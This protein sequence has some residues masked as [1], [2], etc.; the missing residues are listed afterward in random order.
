MEFRQTF[1]ENKQTLMQLPKKHL[2][3]N[4]WIQQTSV[5]RTQPLN[6]PSVSQTDFPSVV[7]F[8]CHFSPEKKMTTLAE[9][10]LREMTFPFPSPSSNVTYLKKHWCLETLEISREIIIHLHFIRTVALT[11]MPIYG[12]SQCCGAAVWIF[13]VTCW[14][15]QVVKPVSLD[16]CYHLFGWLDGSLMMFVWFIN[17]YYVIMF[18]SLCCWL[19][20][21]IYVCYM[22]GL[23]LPEGDHCRLLVPGFDMANHDPRSHN[24]SPPTT[25]PPL[26]DVSVD[27]LAGTGRTHTILEA[28]NFLKKIFETFGIKPEIMES[29]SM[30]TAGWS[31]CLDRL[32]RLWQRWRGGHWKRRFFLLVGKL[33]EN[34]VEKVCCFF[35]QTPCVFKLRVIAFA[36]FVDESFDV[37]AISDR[38]AS[39]TREPN[40][41]IQASEKAEVFLYRWKTDVASHDATTLVAWWIQGESSLTSLVCSLA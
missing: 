15:M 24:D 5:W 31:C 17:V 13:H 18:S 1:G 39:S 19:D 11:S 7:F 2:L 3:T 4:V 33:K 29:S 32:R 20:V 30:V 6:K 16:G 8:L 25:F 28:Y 35:F 37:R 40:L 14:L 27:R 22:P 26:R 12:P 41:D 10:T 23:P 36:H 38:Y 9:E 34:C 21:C